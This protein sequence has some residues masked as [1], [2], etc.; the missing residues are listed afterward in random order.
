M[1]L[2]Y[3]FFLPLLVLLSAGCLKNNNADNNA[4]PVP[5]GTFSGQFIRLHKN[6]AGVIDTVKASLVLTLDV[7]TGYKVTGDTTKHAGSYGDFALDPNY[8]LFDDKTYNATGPNLKSHLT[9]QYL[10][11]YD[12]TRLQ[13]Q[14]TSIDTLTLFYDLTKN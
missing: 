14:Q 4:T 9:G 7:K 10:Y 2:K 5:T 11:A 3:V 12:G 8:F 6:Q 13:L 1:K